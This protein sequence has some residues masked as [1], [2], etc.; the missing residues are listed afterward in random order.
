M[1]VSKFTL[2]PLGPPGP[3][4]T[5]EGL[6]QALLQRIGILLVSY[7]GGMVSG[8]VT[9]INTTSTY[10]VTPLGLW[11]VSGDPTVAHLA[12]AYNVL[13][14]YPGRINASAESVQSAEYGPPATIARTD[15]LPVRNIP[16]LSTLEALAQ[17]AL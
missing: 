11:L 4:E 16:P 9:V 12:K 3:R 1:T 14:S 13:R 2:E 10:A 6:H 17:G 15:R 5:A 7:P 8:W